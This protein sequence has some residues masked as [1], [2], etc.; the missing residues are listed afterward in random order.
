MDS[1]TYINKKQSY[2]G[3]NFIFIFIFFTS[4]CMYSHAMGFYV[5]IY[6]WDFL[7]VKIELV[8]HFLLKIFKNNTSTL[9]YV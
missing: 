5:P 9:P 3:Y 6:Y 4:P 1:S 2:P 8:T 7:C